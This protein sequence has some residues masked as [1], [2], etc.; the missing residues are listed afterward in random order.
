[1]AIASINP[2]N[3]ERLKSFEAATPAAIEAALARAA[4]TFRSW[5]ETPF[6]ERAARMA[7]AAEILESD[8]RRFG[9]TMTLEIPVW[10]GTPN[11]RCRPSNP[12]NVKMTHN[13]P[14][15]RSLTVTAVGS[16]AK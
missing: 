10:L 3:G 14:G 8:K 5:R 2:A 15:A 11:D 1:M 7:K 4:A 16:H 12:E 9:E 6:A 13:T